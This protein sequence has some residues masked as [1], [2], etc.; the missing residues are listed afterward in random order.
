MAE[1]IL[2]KI[3][4]DAAE[5]RSELSASEKSLEALRTTAQSTNNTPL[6]AEAEAA[7]KAID[8]ELVSV[9][10]TAK[11]S[12]ASIESIGEAAAKLDRA[13]RAVEDLGTLLEKIKDQGLSAAS[14]LEGVSD[15]TRAGAEAGVQSSQQLKAATEAFLEALTK[16]EQGADAANAALEKLGSAPAEFLA[17]ASTESERLALR[18]ADLA[19]RTQNLAKAGEAGLGP[20]TNQA[21]RARVSLAELKAEVDSLGD[22]ASPQLRA[23]LARLE[24]RLEN[25][26]KAGRERARAVAVELREVG[27]QAGLTGSSLRSLEETIFELGGPKALSGLVKVQ[28]ALFA[29]S[30]IRVFVDFV[31]DIDEFIKTDPAIQG[32]VERITQG[33]LDASDAVDHAASGTGRLANAIIIL[34]NAGLD[35]P[36]NFREILRAAESL[37][38]GQELQIEATKR[39]AEALRK[40]SEDAFGVN[41][42]KLENDIRAASSA[43]I[44]LADQAQKPSDEQILSI[45]KAIE[46]LLEQAELAG[47]NIDQGLVE[48]LKRLAAVAGVSEFA[49]DRLTDAAKKNQEAL[50]S[51]AEELKRLDYGREEIEKAADALEDLDAKVT[52]LSTTG[53]RDLGQVTTEAADEMLAAIEALLKQIAL[54]DPETRKSFEK[55]KE[56]AEGLRGDYE[57]LG[58]E[59]ERTQIEALKKVEEE[60]KAS[61]QRRL[62]IEKGLANSLK[63]LALQLA[64]AVSPESEEGGDAEARLQSKEAEIAALEEQQRQGSLTI[65]Q[66]EKLHSLHL[67]TSDLLRQVAKEAGVTTTEWKKGLGEV[68]GGQTRVRQLLAELVTGNEDFRQGFQSLDTT[69]KQAIQSIITQLD[70]T[71]EAGQLT[72]GDLERAAQNIE[73]TFFA[74]GVQVED[75][76]SIIGAASGQAGSLQQAFESLSEAGGDSLDEIREKAEQTAEAQESMAES[77]TNLKDALELLEGKPLKTLEKAESLVKSLEQRL[78]STLEICIK[79]SNCLKGMGDG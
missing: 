60:A 66:V 48:E 76:S 47:G 71:A 58:S 20:F 74:A 69:A 36:D 43:L 49:I 45:A 23:E 19:Q 15:R 13:K 14:G 25:T 21:A 41:F 56:Y 17:D 57:K 64:D 31:K 79:L 1:D 59:Y 35:V 6:F 52:G 18:F 33:F 22:R 78:A 37:A 77:V 75:L 12:A 55:L 50:K 73:D 53:V 24:A 4:G 5:L 8:S 44:S 7:L 40:L 3:G 29:L 68:E 16:T 28:S 11:D 51:H 32:A 54:L 30:Q 42:T 39:Q 70:A 61:A 26:F 10:A 38:R 62:E 72:S 34:K 2:V 46:R 63:E 27:D 9:E 67:E 65:A